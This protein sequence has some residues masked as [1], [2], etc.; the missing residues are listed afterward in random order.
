MNSTFRNTMLLAVISAILCLPF[1]LVAVFYARKSM[2]FRKKDLPE[3]A[4][5]NSIHANR[6]SISAIIAG[7]LFW[8]LTILRLKTM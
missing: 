8:S 3:N 1:G 7:L 4:R 2:E 5:L 6:W